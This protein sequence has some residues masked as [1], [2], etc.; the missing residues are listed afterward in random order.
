MRQCRFALKI[1]SLTTCV[2]FSYEQ[3]LYAYFTYW[4]NLFGDELRKSF[5][6]LGG[7]IDCCL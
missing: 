4:T 5:S 2:N 3:K 7:E 6:G 1:I